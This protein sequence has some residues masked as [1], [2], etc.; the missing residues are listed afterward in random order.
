M[1][2]LLTPCP[3]REHFIAAGYGIGKP[4]FGQS[5]TRSTKVSHFARQIVLYEQQRSHAA[6]AMRA[7]S[8]L[9]A[10]DL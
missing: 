5:L 2:S 3:Q 10:G 7:V 8:F 4:Q 6:C 9:R 1:P